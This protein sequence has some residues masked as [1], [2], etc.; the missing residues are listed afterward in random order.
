MSTIEYR[1]QH[2]KE[3]TNKFVVNINIEVFDQELELPAIRCC[4]NCAQLTS[5][6]LKIIKKG[7]V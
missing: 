1:C 2:C 6:R 3:L 7:L 4:E 5:V